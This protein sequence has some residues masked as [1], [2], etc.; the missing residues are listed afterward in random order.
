MHFLFQYNRRTG[1]LGKPISFSGVDGGRRA[2]EARF[3]AESATVDPDVE[4][5]VIEAESEHA[6]RRTHP[7]YFRTVSELA[8]DAQSAA[9]IA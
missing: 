6:M 1:D 9:A 8:G 2:L 5:V 4:I 7:R 3:K